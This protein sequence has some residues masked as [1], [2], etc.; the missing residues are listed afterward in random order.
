M[1]TV[2][3]VGAAG[4]SSARRPLPRGQP[5]EWRCY[6]CGHGLGMMLRKSSKKFEEL[7]PGL[8]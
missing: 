1:K 4:V 2:P 8:V 7:P 3:S 5:R 6:A